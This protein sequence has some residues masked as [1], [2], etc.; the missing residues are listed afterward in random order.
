MTSLKNEKKKIGPTLSPP[1]SQR[2]KLS[3]SSSEAGTKPLA[4]KPTM[5]AVAYL[6]GSLAWEDKQVPEPFT[7]VLM[8]LI[9]LKI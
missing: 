1:L 2:S 5:H 4:T 3:P 6:R 7:G 8:G 9:S